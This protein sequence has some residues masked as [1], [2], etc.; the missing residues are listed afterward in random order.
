MTELIPTLISN[1][2]AS[3]SLQITLASGATKT[4]GVDKELRFLIHFLGDIHQPLHAATNADA[5]GNCVKV[6]G[7]SGS[8]NLHSTWD[9]ALVSKIEQPTREATVTALLAGV[10]EQRTGRRR[11]G[12]EDDRVRCSRIF[13]SVFSRSPLLDSRDHRT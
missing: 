5:G 12:P 10:R 4:F 7:F 6:T 9:T 13:A 3:K 2:K 11:D 8:A 1:I